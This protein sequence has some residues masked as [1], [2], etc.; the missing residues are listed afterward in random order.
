[1]AVGSFTSVSLDPPLVAFFADKGSTTF[2]EIEASRSFCVNVLGAHQEQ[3][4]RKFSRSGSDRF[5][6]IKWQPSP[7]GSP[8]LE[9]V[10]AWIDCDIDSIQ[11]AGDHYLAVG[12]VRALDTG[13]PSLPLMFLRGGYGEFSSHSLVVAEEPG[14]AR[15]V[16]F[17]SIARPELEALAADLG[18]ECT[19]SANVNSN[20]V[21][22]ASAGSSGSDSGPP[23]V[24]RRIPMLPPL[25][26][27]FMAWEDEASIDAWLARSPVPI[28]SALRLRY[29]ESMSKVRDRGW[30]GYRSD[31]GFAEID[32]FAR[33]AYSEGAHGGAS[34][35]FERVVAEL[36]PGFDVLELDGEEKVAVCRLIAPVLG[37]DG[38]VCL[39]VNAHL[40][41]D[42]CPPKRVEYV[43][44][45][46]LEASSRVAKAIR[47][48][49]G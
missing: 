20:L 44:D 24:G 1:M 48:A 19:V 25:G 40:S 6:G 8:I 22:L 23:T 34:S 30:L 11:E 43:R 9:D 49:N 12:R 10:V 17:S 28:D 38:R 32:R 45:R 3:T 35:A 26:T 41:G 4:C 31:T 21:V 33:R 27:Q 18:T 5:E 36:D 14:L 42:P 2:P 29:E 13:S 39:A 46:V 37:P 7:T 16:R 47:A 15:L